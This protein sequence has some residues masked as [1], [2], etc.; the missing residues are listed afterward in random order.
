MVDTQA[1]Q[2]H[3]RLYSSSLH[4]GGEISSLHK[5]SNI[6]VTSIA[7][8]GSDKDAAFLVKSVI[9]SVCAKNV[10]SLPN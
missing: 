1:A 4:G 5:E 3:V 7:S 9:F 2:K 8:Y 10:F 6:I